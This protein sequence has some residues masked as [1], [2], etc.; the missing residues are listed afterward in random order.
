MDMATYWNVCTR[1]VHTFTIAYRT[2]SCVPRCVSGELYTSMDGYYKVTPEIA[3][4]PRLR[5]LSFRYPRDPFSFFLSRN[6]QAASGVRVP[7]T[8]MIQIS[9]ALRTVNGYAL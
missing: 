5:G 2:L 8:V 9:K 4:R 7:Y 6:L 1:Y 3:Y